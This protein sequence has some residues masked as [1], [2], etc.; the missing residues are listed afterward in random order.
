VRPDPRSA[1]ALLRIA[2]AFNHDSDSGDYALAKQPGINWKNYSD[3][4]ANA[5]DEPIT[6]EFQEMDSMLG[7]QFDPFWQNKRTPKELAEAIAAP[8][9]ELLKKAIRS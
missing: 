2:T 1:A 7:K 9:V 8:T 4:L 6:T 5:R 3:G